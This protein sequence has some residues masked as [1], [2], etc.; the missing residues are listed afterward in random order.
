LVT[1]L[2]LASRHGFLLNFVDATVTVTAQTQLANYVAT[3]TL[4]G[5]P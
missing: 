3:G 4:S 5:C 1:D 2:S